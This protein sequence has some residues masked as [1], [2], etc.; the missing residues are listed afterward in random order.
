M[1]GVHPVAKEQHNED[2][3]QAFNYGIRRDGLVYD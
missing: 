3:V 1:L 2:Q